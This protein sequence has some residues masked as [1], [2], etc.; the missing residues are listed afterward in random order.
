MFDMFEQEPVSQ[1]AAPP[2]KRPLIMGK[3][4][5]EMDTPWPYEKS[6]RPDWLAKVSFKPEAILTE[7]WKDLTRRRPGNE[8]THIQAW[9]VHREMYGLRISE[10]A[11]ATLKYFWQNKYLRCS[12]TICCYAP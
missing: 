1:Q 11:D 4:T 12:N 7:V 9:S 3:I 6:K 10:G 2:D 8:G 5:A